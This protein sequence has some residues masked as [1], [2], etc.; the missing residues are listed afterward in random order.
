IYHGF[1]G[2]NRSLLKTQI[3]LVQVKSPDAQP[4]LVVVKYAAGRKAQVPYGVV[5]NNFVR[6]FLF[7]AIIR[8]LVAKSKIG[9]VYFSGTITCLQPS[10]YYKVFRNFGM[11][12]VQ[13][14]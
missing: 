5:T 12:T 8:K 13:T 3:W 2:Q 11:I 14:A 6:K 9:V 10:T 4:K 1:Y 7:Q